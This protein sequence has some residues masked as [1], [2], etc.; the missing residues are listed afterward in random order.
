ML[1]QRG[2]ATAQQPIIDLHPAGAQV[3]VSFVMPCLNESRTLEGCIRA[4]QRCIDDNHLAGEVIVAD[5]GSTDGSQDLARRCGARV[6][7]VASKGYG[8]ALMGGIAAARGRYIVMGDSDG[9]YD[10][11]QAM[12]M[13]A[14]LREGCDLVMGNRFPRAGGRIMPG[15]MP[16]KHRYLGN[17]VLSRL[18]QIVFGVPVS[19]FHCGLRAFSKAAYER[20]DVRTTGMEFASELVIKAHTRGM[21]LAEVPITLH[22]DGRDRPPHLRS[23]R[24]GWRHLR[25]MLCLSPRWTLFIPGA[26][27][28][29]IGAVLGAM[30]AI[31]PVHL[32]R[33][34]L[35]LHTLVAAALMLVVGY[36]AMVAGAAMRIFAL[37]EEIGPPSPFLE[38]A[39]KVFTLERGV[40]AGGLACITGL[41]FIAIP[42]W[43]WVR[44]DLGNLDAQRT[45]RPMIV[46]STLLALGVETVLM[47]F[48][49]SMLGMERRR[50]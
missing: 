29:F 48:V 3:E 49:L 9:S 4:A 24:D 41:A 31:G 44:S 47:S 42:V 5:N 38:R 13:I 19:D 33:V 1:A 16:F 21:R 34:Q 15:A 7:D 11:A 46:G 2:P 43:A 22:K 14:R 32:G 30:V 50:G 12:P 23:W 25:F 40:V 35:D 37:N 28:A 10:F 17:P 8:H 45:L 26:V 27:L 6:A 36:Q 20:M 39:F 18:G